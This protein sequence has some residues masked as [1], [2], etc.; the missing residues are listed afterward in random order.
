MDMSQMLKAKQA[1]DTFTRNHPRFPMFLQAVK[2]K[3]I[4]EGTIIDITITDHDGQTTQTN[5]KICQS[6]LDLFETIKNMR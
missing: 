5:L 3:G 4:A 2:N 6:D 1:W